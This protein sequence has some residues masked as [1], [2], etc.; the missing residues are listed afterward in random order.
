MFQRSYM[1]F[2]PHMSTIFCI[3][4][5]II[6]HPCHFEFHILPYTC[7]IY[8]SIAIGYNSVRYLFFNFFI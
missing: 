7:A 3:V 2:I 6:G 5:W 4:I 1:F 8:F